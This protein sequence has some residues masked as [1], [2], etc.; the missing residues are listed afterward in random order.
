[1]TNRENALPRR[2]FP[3]IDFVSSFP[4]HLRRRLR[5]RPRFAMT[6]KRTPVD[7]PQPN[8]S[9]GPIPCVI[10]HCPVCGDGLLGIRICDDHGFVLCDECEAIWTSP[11]PGSSHAYTDAENPSCPVCQQSLYSQSRWANRS[12]VDRL[13][14]TASVNPDL[15][16]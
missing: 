11:D 2:C 16:A 3:F 6:S 15:S 10:D 4:S 7:P 5:H 13:N 1:M 12:E 9:D 8:P 14:W